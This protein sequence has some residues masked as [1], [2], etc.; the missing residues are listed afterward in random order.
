MTRS[1]VLPVVLGFALLVVGLFYTRFNRQTVTVRDASRAGAVG[2][3]QVATGFQKHE[4][5]IWLTVSAIIARL[6]PDSYGR[7]EHQRF[8][9]RCPS[10]QTILIVNDVSIGQRVPVGM[11]QR[12]V[13]RGQYV[14]NRQG[15]LIHFTHHRDG[16]G[17]WILFQ[18]H[19]Y[20]LALL[21]GA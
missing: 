16:N 13:V 3:S 1:N 20:A 9:V 19:V 21:Q 18:G 6:L 4:S 5:G 15:G 12:V 8:I 7:N 2:C 10:G 17:G 11:G 14:W